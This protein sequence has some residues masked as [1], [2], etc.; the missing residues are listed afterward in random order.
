MKFL[1]IVALLS[2]S[3]I[4]VFASNSTVQGID[5]HGNWCGGGHGGLQDCCDGGQ[6]PSCDLNSGPTDACLQECPPVD[7]MDRACVDHDFC[8]SLHVK[9]ID[10]SPE[11]NFCACDCALVA[12]SYGEN[13]CDSVYCNAY[14]KG[15]RMTFQDGTACFSGEGSDQVCHP[16]PLHDDLNKFC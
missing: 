1:T 15:L 10:C 2:A 14:V 13:M 12:A 5:S 11:G 16:R 9:E 8:C 4:A 6:C 3:A 7:G